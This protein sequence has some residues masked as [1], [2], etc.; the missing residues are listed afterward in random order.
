MV[1]IC[2]C[3][4]KTNVHKLTWWCRRKAKV[5][6]GNKTTNPSVRLQ[7]VRILADRMSVKIITQV[8]GGIRFLIKK[9]TF[10]GMSSDYP[11]HHSVVIDRLR[12]AGL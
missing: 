5:R 1:F 7:G 8:N 10:F 12:V 11:P 6:I 2:V 3:A 4:T 9:K